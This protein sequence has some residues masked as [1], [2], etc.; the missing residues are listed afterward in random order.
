MPNYLNPNICS[1]A[2]SQDL[3]SCQLKRGPEY[4]ACT[5]RAGCTST[6]NGGL[7]PPPF[8]LDPVIRVCRT[9]EAYTAQQGN[10]LPNFTTSKATTYSGSV[11]STMPVSICLTEKSN[12]PS[13]RTTVT[14][15]RRLPRPVPLNA[16]NLGFKEGRES[17]T[18]TQG[19]N[20]Q[21]RPQPR[22]RRDARHR[23]RAAGPGQNIRE[24]RDKPRSLP[25]RCRGW[26]TTETHWIEEGEI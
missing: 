6:Q 17:P 10:Y 3:F 11:L 25:G 22:G 9:G 20:F 4:L 19:E 16:P 23:P 15:R 26:G 21:P 18:W 1:Q 12:F 7:P 24:E 8:R 14:S 5:L 2:V 13:D